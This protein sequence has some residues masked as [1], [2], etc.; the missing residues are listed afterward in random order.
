[1]E[2]SDK[3]KQDD[4]KTI[5]LRAALE[6]LIECGKGPYVKHALAARVFY[7]EAECDGA[8]LA[9]DIAIELGLEEPF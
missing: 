7:D 9:N 5:L 2:L 4:R 3:N 6:L 8:A 1:M